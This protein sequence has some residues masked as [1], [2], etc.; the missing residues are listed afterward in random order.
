MNH[1]PLPAALCH[2]PQIGTVRA[3]RL[4]KAGCARWP[5]L[6]VAADPLRLGR[7]RWE[8]V[9]G[10]AERSLTAMQSDDACALTRLLRAR[11]HWRILAHW[12]D[13]ASFFDIETSGLEA[14][15]EVTVVTCLHAGELHRFVR[16][17]NLEGFLPLLEEMRLLVSFNGAGF[18]VP[19]IL[20]LFHIP[21]LPCA[22][23]DLRWMS[24]HAGWRGG[25]KDIESRQGVR[26]P[27]DLV[28]VDG[29]AAVWLWQA[30]KERRQ[31][32][33]RRRLTRYCAADTV[34]LKLLAAR[35][36]D[37][38]GH[39]PECV[40]EA[41][42]LWRLVDDACPVEPGDDELTPPPPENLPAARRPAT[43]QPVWPG[44]GDLAGMLRNLAGFDQEARAS[45]QARLRA[46]WRELRVDM[47]SSPSQ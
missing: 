37:A 26:R 12:F 31:E 20:D 18:D 28:G 1:D 39:A 14:G 47:T 41:A 23:V 17:E 15:S 32:A 10:A 22:H 24:Y 3:E 4:V 25:L 45:R 33:A 8:A 21:E 11:D 13:R 36:L 19:R 38:H 5:E 16:D 6:L 27:A 7:A 34:A 43:P 29:A 35:L 46:K 40:P 9:R 30:W 2:L 42:A 44:S